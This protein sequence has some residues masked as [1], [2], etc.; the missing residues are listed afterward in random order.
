MK[1]C[2]SLCIGFSIY[3]ILVLFSIE[4]IVTKEIFGIFIGSIILI[5]CNLILKETEFFTNIKLK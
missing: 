1:K 4:L 3:I 2:I 5:L